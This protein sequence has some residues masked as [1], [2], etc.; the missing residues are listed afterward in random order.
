MMD[1]VINLPLDPIKWIR[2][3]QSTQGLIQNA[4]TAI[5]DIC[6]KLC[7]LKTA[8]RLSFQVIVITELTAFIQEPMGQSVYD[9]GWTDNAT[10]STFQIDP[11]LLL[12]TKNSG[13]SV[14]CSGGN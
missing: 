2:A 4:V 11:H 3:Q 9:P 5:Q 7:V 6:S 13:P 1:I 8:G 14:K 12:S 10:I